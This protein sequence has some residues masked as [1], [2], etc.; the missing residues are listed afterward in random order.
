MASW[1]ATGMENRDG[2]DDR[3]KEQSPSFVTSL[4]YLL[5][6]FHQ[7]K[8]D[9][10]QGLP[11]PVTLRILIARHRRMLRT[12]LFSSSWR[13]QCWRL[14]RTYEHPRSPANLR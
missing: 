10:D 4:P 2:V 9:R 6:C 3:G 7:T 13:L 11:W 8:H 12:Y 5:G 1:P 14:R